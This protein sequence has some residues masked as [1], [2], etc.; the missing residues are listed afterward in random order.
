MAYLAAII[1]FISECSLLLVSTE[2]AISWLIIGSPLGH[3]LAAG[4]A[5]GF[6][7]AAV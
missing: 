6:G 4:S 5:G 7:P 1:V 3:S 2:Q